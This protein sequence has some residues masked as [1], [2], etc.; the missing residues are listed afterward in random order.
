MRKRACVATKLRLSARRSFRISVVSIT[1]LACA[2]PNSLLDQRVIVDLSH[3][4]T[5]DTIY[6]PTEEGFVL[7]GGSAGMTDKGYWYSANR[8]RSAEHGGTHID[9]P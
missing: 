3:S 4:Y 5:S 6:W 9:A 7:E 1:L 8:F 2:S